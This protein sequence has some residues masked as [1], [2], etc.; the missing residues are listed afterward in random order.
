MPR[1]GTG[2]AIAFRVTVRTAFVWC[3]FLLLATTIRSS[4]PQPGVQIEMRNVRLHVDDGIVLD[5]SRLRGVMISRQPGRTPVFDDQRSYTLQLRSAEISMDMASLQNLMN[6]H[7][8]AYEGAP[9]RDLTVEPDG[10]RLKMK[11]KLH[12]GIDIPFSTTASVSSTN[13]GLMRLRV[14][15]MKAVGIPAKGLLDLFGLELDDVMDIK[16]RRGVDVHDDDILISAGRVLPPPEIVGRL[17]R[18][19]VE[20]RRLVQRFD[21]A[22]VGRAARLVKPS[23]GARNYI[24]FGGGDITFGKLTMHDADLQLIDLDPRDPFDFFPSRYTAQ[25]VAGYSKNTPSKG[26]K[27]YMPDFDDLKKRSSKR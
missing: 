11:G 17:T 6:R 19:S 12:K 26:L 4:S 25:L 10:A 9:L 14:E 16:N 7:V 22:S 15:S 21:D 23:P 3:G 2:V 13:D 24:Y 18:V 5:V 8:F 1:I 27:T 20:G